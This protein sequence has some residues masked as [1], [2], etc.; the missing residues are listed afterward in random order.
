MHTENPDGTAE[1]NFTGE[2]EIFSLH[3]TVYSTSLS[4]LHNPVKF[5]S[6]T[7]YLVV[8]L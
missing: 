7:D 8:Y 5:M 1:F 2:Y 3:E 6:L 4:L